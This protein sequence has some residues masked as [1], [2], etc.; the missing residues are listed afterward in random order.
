MQG[1]AD[2]QADKDEQHRILWALNNAIPTPCRYRNLMIALT[3]LMADVARLE[4]GEADEHAAPPAPDPDW[5]RGE[6]RGPA[7][8]PR[9]RACLMAR[10]GSIWPISS[11]TWR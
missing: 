3:N 11:T 9:S 7:V 2:T 6:G 8:G 4:H 1:F 5:R 10:A